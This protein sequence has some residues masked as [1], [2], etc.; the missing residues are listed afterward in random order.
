M[1]SHVQ[2]TLNQL[3]FITGALTTP[4]GALRASLGYPKPWKIKYVEIG[5][6]DNIYGG[7]P[8]YISYRFQAYYDAITAKFPDITV[9]ASTVALVLPS[10]AVGDYHQYS[11]PD[12]LVKQ[13]SYFD[14]NDTKH[15]AL[16][17]T[18]P[19]CFLYLLLRGESIWEQD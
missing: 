11:Y 18:C 1:S 7:L 12:E 8:S 13:F 14:L 16:N 17:G 5:N 3:E 2:D 6:E 9:M 19:N 15:T 10:K 4:F